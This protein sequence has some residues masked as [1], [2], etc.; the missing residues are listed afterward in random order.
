MT[1]T[2]PQRAPATAA[3]AF[4]E[5]RAGNGVATS[6]VGPAGKKSSPP[7]RSSASQ[8][9]AS[10][11]NALTVFAADCE[12]NSCMATKLR[13]K[14][15]DRDI[16]NIDVSKAKIALLSQRES[17]EIE[18]KRN[19]HQLVLQREAAD[20]ERKREENQLRIL[21]LQLQLQQTQPAALGGDNFAQRPLFINNNDINNFAHHADAF[22]WD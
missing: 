18:R 1:P 6:K 10:K 9:S 13:D 3:S 14:K 8:P 12:N 17:G 5:S 7:S 4:G 11:Q 15:L 21:Q 16:G 19:E 20:S 22:K 2:P